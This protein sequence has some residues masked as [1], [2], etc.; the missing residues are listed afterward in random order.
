MQKISG[1][2]RD[3]CGYVY[4]DGG[5]I[6]RTLNSMY[7]EHWELALS[8]GLLGALSGRHFLPEY[9]EIEPLEGSWKTLEV[10]EI[11]WISYPYEWSFY[12]L[13]DAARLTLE[14]Q[15]E[16]LER[17]LTLKDASAYNVQFNGA[18]PVFIDLLSFEKRAPDSPWSG[19]RQFCMQFL[20]PLALA[21]HDPRLGRLSAGWI[22]GIPLN[23]AWKLL[24]WRAGFSA[25]LQL[26][27]HL[28]GRAERK[29]GDARRADAKVRQAKIGGKALL[30][31]VGSLRRTVD[32]L[33][34]PTLPGDWTDYYADTNY[35]ESATAAKQRI[36]ETA[37]GQAGGGLAHD[38]GANTGRFSAIMAPYFKQVIASDMDA[39]AV[40]RHYMR[41]KKNGDGKILPL[42]LD[43]S[44]P[45]PGIGWDNSERMPWA[46]RGAANFVCALA[47]THHLYFT[48][49]IPWERQVAFFAGL[50]RV[51]GSLLLEFVPREDSQV[52]RMLAARDDIFTDY[53]LDDL[54]GALGRRFLEERIW[55]L[56]DS[57]RSLIL[58]K[59][60][61]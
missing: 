43:L 27:L 48:E 31:L 45:S 61:Q 19:Y 11:P 47:L 54:R 10:E 8:S 60:F 38:L 13:R 4:A 26:H 2:F 58:L 59:K 52:R 7:R 6:I 28:H 16:A 49:G 24:P 34:G 29:Y 25:G 51:G 41:L 12:Q 46:G 1:S 3:P 23:L 35:S 57:D 56:P 14:I 30:E 37:A 42:V 9:R 20:A 33:R 21:V 5:R 40:A 39:P 53:T 55:P 44:N 17:G 36:V 32:S 18:R 22:G 50:L 15:A